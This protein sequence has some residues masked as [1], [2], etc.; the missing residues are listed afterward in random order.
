MNNLEF[1]ALHNRTSGKIIINAS[2]ILF[3]SIDQKIK[4]SIPLSSIR[5][6]LHGQNSNHFEIENIFINEHSITVQDDKVIEILQNHG[7]SSAKEVLKNSRE[8]HFVKKVFYS[9]PIMIILFLIILLPIVL[10]LTPISWLNKIISPKV[11][12]K[13]LDSIFWPIIQKK[14]SISNNLKSSAILHELAHELSR[15]NP[16]LSEYN[17]KIEVSDSNEFNAYSLPGARLIF[18]RGLIEE[19]ESC[20]EILGVLAHEMAHTEQRHVIKSVGSSIGA[21]IAFTTLSLIVGVNAASSIFKVSNFLDLKFSREDETKADE[22]GLEFIIKS[23]HSPKG[24]IAFFSKLSKKNHLP[25]ELTFLSTHPNSND[26]AT[27][28]Q[29]LLEKSMIKPTSEIICDLNTL[30]SFN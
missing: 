7:V 8:K 4:F 14:F 24:M 19:V 5:I 13:Y 17:W 21:I 6:K 20:S 18:N 3:E 26:R 30:K 28:L 29:S 9:S 25:S 22:R 1:S 10:S 15:K 2:N 12:E 11:E 23:G 16:N 27:H